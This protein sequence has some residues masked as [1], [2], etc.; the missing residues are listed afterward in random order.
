MANHRDGRALRRLTARLVMLSGALVLA[1]CGIAVSATTGQRRGITNRDAVYPP[2]P[3]TWSAPSAIDP[4]GLTAISC[5][6][7]SLCVAGDVQGQ[8][9]A[10]GNPGGGASAWNEPVDADPSVNEFGIESVSC[11]S[12]SL[13]VAVD[14][15]GNLVTST[16]A[17]GVNSW[18]S[19][20]NVDGNPPDDGL[21]GV[22]CPTISL[23]VAV[24]FTGHV[25]TSTNPTGGASAWSS[26][27]AVDSTNAF[28]AVSCASSTLCVAVDSGGNVVTSTNP[29]G[30]ASAWSAPVAIGSG[31]TLTSVSCPSVS[32]CVV[33]DSSGYVMT[34]TSPAGGADAWSAPVRIDSNYLTSVSCGAPTLCVAVDFKGNAIASNDPTAGTTG[35]ST[36]TQ[37][38]HSALHV[39]CPSVQLCVAIDRTGNALIGEPG[40]PVPISSR[41]PVISGTAQR[42]QTL[43]ESH[44]TWSNNPTSYSYQWEDCDS[45]EN[46]CAAIAGA[47]SQTYT[48][49]SSD[50]GHTIRVQETARNARRQQSR[51]DLCGDGRGAAAL[52]AGDEAGE[53]LAAG[54]LGPE[55]GR[56][57]AV[58]IGR[59]LVRH[60]VDLLR[61]PVATVRT[62]VL[63]H[64]RR[65]H[66]L[67]HTVAA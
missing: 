8:T 55:Q 54:D 33:S 4:T 6:S 26:P 34:S 22:S 60:V 61:L 37:I 66:K 64:R 31:D 46:S 65:H 58:R 3:L 17:T 2:S 52:G 67:A 14:D 44:G 27:I 24:D 51:R 32:L 11:A 49:A 48:L 47:T 43:A 1:I 29:A 18:S 15:K 16:T 39:S 28:Y 36:P 25:V 23:C 57:D 41:P 9:V 20:V 12:T 63:G 30:G 5:P 38:D 21:S 59:R 56:A 7:A 45:S 35:W 42:G 53:Q 13:C 40:T 19:P 10:S 62:R 50:V